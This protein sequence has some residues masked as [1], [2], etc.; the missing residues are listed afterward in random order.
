MWP[1]QCQKW[2]P[3]NGPSAQYASKNVSNIVQ[4]NTISFRHIHILFCIIM[5]SVHSTV[6]IKRNRPMPYSD[7]LQHRVLLHHSRGLSSLAITDA[8]SDEWLRATR[9]GIAKFLRRVEETK[10]LERQPGSC[11]PSSMTSQMLAL[12]EE[13]MRHDDETATARTPPPPRLQHLAVNCSP[14]PFLA[15]MDV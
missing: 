9:Q 12:V 1:S 13:Q 5:L 8:L 6:Q 4:Y 10:S 2:P 3:N 14:Q 15:G 7:Y 11:R